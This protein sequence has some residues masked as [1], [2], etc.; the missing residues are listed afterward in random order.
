MLER[1]CC[2]RNGIA[3]VT[4]LEAANSYFAYQPVL[5]ALQGTS[6]ASLLLGEHL[7]YAGTAQVTCMFNHLK[8]VDAHVLQ[9]CMCS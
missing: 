7:Q 1:L 6:G 4:L 9:H 3:K 5:K 2:N 8:V